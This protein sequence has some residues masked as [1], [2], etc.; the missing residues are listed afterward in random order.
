MILLSYDFYF[1]CDMGEPDG[2]QV[3]DPTVYFPHVKAD[4]VI[5]SWGQQ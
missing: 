1:L 5:V 4:A 3:A 2:E